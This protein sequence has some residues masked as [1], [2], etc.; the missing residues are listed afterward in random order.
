MFDTV[1]TVV[2]E[3]LLFL[4]IMGTLYEWWKSKR[5]VELLPI[6][7][8]VL[9]M[10]SFAEPFVESVLHPWIAGLTWLGIGLCVRVVIRRRKSR[11]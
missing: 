4:L 9:A 3:L 6:V 7:L 1:I 10:C 2:F 8:Y 11:D 5:H